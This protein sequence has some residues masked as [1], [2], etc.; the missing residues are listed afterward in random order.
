M[1]SAGLA[2]GSPWGIG[3]WDWSL[4]NQGGSEH[5]SGNVRALGLPHESSSLT[6]ND[7][8]TRMHTRPSC[9]CRSPRNCFL[10]I[11]PMPI[12]LKLLRWP[13]A[14]GMCCGVCKKEFVWKISWQQLV[15]QPFSHRSSIVD[16][17]ANPSYAFMSTMNTDLTDGTPN[18]SRTFWIK[19]VPPAAWVTDKVNC[20]APVIS[21]IYICP[22]VNIINENRLKHD[23]L[24]V[25]CLG[26]FELKPKANPVTCFIS[27]MSVNALPKCGR[28][29]PHRCGVAWEWR[30][31]GELRNMP[32]PGV[33][34]RKPPT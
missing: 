33:G 5:W 27:W 6:P 29:P 10:D 32:H 8:C 19:S 7:R 1:T 17:A 26:K 22:H 24:E 28:F 9:P 12:S 21:H 31:L 30:Q 11:E 4:E 15:L 16:I 13:C 14:V 18:P 25:Q 34:W 20:V 2:H 23:R 3:Q